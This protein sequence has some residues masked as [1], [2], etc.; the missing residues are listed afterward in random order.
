MEQQ[1]ISEYLTTAMNFIEVHPDVQKQVMHVADYLKNNCDG[2]F[3]ISFLEPRNV[4]FRF[5]YK[6]TPYKTCNI[7]AVEDIFVT[8]FG[9]S[10][11]IVKILSTRDAKVTARVFSRPF[12]V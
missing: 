4:N 1:T 9:R 12:T 2:E 8:E 11:V 7:D 6:N 5:S 10:N 3:E